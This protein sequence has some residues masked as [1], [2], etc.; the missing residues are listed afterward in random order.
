LISGQSFLNQSFCC[1]DLDHSFM[2]V[3]KKGDRRC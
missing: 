1:I 3:W 2:P